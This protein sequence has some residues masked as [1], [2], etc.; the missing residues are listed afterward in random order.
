MISSAPGYSPSVR[1][2]EAAACAVP[3]ISDAWPGLEEFFQPGKEI[4]LASEASDVLDYLR[5]VHE[6]E[7]R[8][9][10]VRARQRVLESHTADHR[11][12]ELEGHLAELLPACLPTQGLQRGALAV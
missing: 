7:L 9:I 12:R 4:L 2:F 1:L 8:K 6:T 3:I 10:G 5:A 11:A